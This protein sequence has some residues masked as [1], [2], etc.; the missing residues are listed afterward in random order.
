ME[1]KLA[2][3]CRPVRTEQCLDLHLAI[4]FATCLRHASLSFSFSVS[5]QTA[6]ELGEDFLI[7][8]I[9]LF[10][11]LGHTHSNAQWLFLVQELFLA[12]PYGMVAIE[13]GLAH[14]GQRPTR[15]TSNGSG[16]KSL[17]APF[18][19]KLIEK[20]ELG[21]QSVS[22]PGQHRILVPLL[23]QSQD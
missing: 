21:V 9:Y 10:G 1:L 3:P 14:P 11:F 2:K 18:S 13:P 4:Q 20:G 19:R 23:F 12:V 22:A 5:S 7:L 6:L 8:F 15:S 16:K 17:M